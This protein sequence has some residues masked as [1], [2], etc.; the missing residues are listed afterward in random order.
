MQR[1]ARIPFGGARR[2][3]VGAAA[4]V[5]VG[6]PLIL[7]NACRG[8]LRID[9][10]RETVRGPIVDE[11]LE[12]A[13]RY[14][15]WILHEAD[16]ARLRDDIPAALDF[17]GDLDGGN[18]WEHLAHFVIRPTVGYTVVATDT[19][20]FVT[21]HLFHPRDWSSIDLGLHMTHEGDGE[22]LQVVA[23]RADGR[24]VLLYAQAHYVG[25]AWVRA[26]Y[27]AR[28]R[29][30]EPRGH[31]TLV[32]TDGRPRD[33]GS[34]VA[35][36][37]QSG[38]HGIYGVPDPCSNVMVDDT[39]GVHFEGAGLVLRPAL[40]GEVVREPDVASAS[41]TATWPYVLESIPAQL[42]DGLRDGSLVGEGA[43]LDGVV[44]Y[45]GSGRTFDVPRYHE[46]DRFSGPFGPDRGISPFA[47]DFDFEP[48][49]LGALL[50]DPAARWNEAL[51]LPGEWGEALVVDPFSEGW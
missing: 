6:V 32:D 1:L 4:L 36:Y 26:G 34:H 28:G 23:Q 27:G 16:P 8:P 44:G 7:L 41:P 50:F 22:N 17:D 29:S 13:Q 48:P 3:C 40:Q 42:W 47:V 51:V 33:D 15:P 37:V 19:H 5:V 21:Y 12:I 11:H 46:G 39:G 45:R 31:L 35:V 30:V 25:E 38:G 2:R 43:L 20:W 18:N 9:P 49:H 24:V 14:A 10:L